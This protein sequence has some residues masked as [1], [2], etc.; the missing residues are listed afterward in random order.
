MGSD[1]LT[2]GQS[3]FLA[4]TFLFITMQDSGEG[5]HILDDSTPEAQEASADQAI[6]AECEVSRA[7]APRHTEAYIHD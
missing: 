6:P 7:G 3:A 5:M 1:R 2:H 4:F